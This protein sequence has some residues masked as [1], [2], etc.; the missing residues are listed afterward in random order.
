[1]LLCTQSH[2]RDLARCQHVTC[3]GSSYLQ[4]VFHWS[5]CSSRCKASLDAHTTWPLLTDGKTLQAQMPTLEPAR[6]QTS[7][8]VGGHHCRWNAELGSRTWLD[9]N[10]GAAERTLRGHRAR[11]STDGRTSH[12][13]IQVCCAWLLVRRPAP[14]LRAPKVNGGGDPRGAALRAVDRPRR[15]RPPSL[16]CSPAPRCRRPRRPPPRP[17]PR[18]GR[19]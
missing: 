17:A 7:S 16:R 4:G 1:M 11:R 2:A 8:C 15:R 3:S 12:S 6:P 13:P 14:R 5:A 18:R 19:R 10:C 9:T